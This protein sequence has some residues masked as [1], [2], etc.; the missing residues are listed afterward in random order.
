MN[1]AVAGLIWGLLVIAAGEAVQAAA[2]RHLRRF[3][4]SALAGVIIA[5]ATGAAALARRHKQLA[6]A[7]ASTHESLTHL[8][9]IAL[10]GLAVAVTVLAYIT[11]TVLA[12]RRARRST[13]QYW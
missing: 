6:A 11:A 8:M 12:S 1:H 3:A 7:A 4:V 9:T 5:A 13:A 2:T 10:A